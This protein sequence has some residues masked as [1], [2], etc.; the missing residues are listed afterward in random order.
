LRRHAIRPQ[1]AEFTA[2]DMRGWYRPRDLLGLD[3]ARVIPEGTA[4]EEA[5]ALIAAAF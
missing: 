4:V 1:V 5:I 2:D 3:G